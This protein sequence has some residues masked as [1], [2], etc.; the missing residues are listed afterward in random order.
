MAALFLAPEYGNRDVFGAPEKQKRKVSKDFSQGSG[1]LPRSTY[2]NIPWARPTD[3]EP[4]PE[5]SAAA[6]P[7]YYSSV[8]K[9][10]VTSI[11][12]QGA[13]GTCSFFAAAS[14][15]ESSALRNRLKVRNTRLTRKNLDLSEYQLAYFMY[16]R[17]TDPLKMTA[18]DTVRVNGDYLILGGN[19]GMNSMRL[20]SWSGPVKEKLAPYEITGKKLAS[21]LAYSQDL[22]HVQGVYLQNPSNVAAVKRLIRHLGA[23][24]VTFQSDYTYFDD[25]YCSYY[26][27]YSE[28]GNHSVSLVGWDDNFSR[29]HFSPYTPSEDGAW[30]IKNSWGDSMG[31]NGFYWI[32]YEDKSLVQDFA[33]AYDTESVENYD[34]N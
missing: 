19:N 21:S 30:L 25:D 18:G 28:K 10:Y 26:C 13:W 2:M 33:I 32:S 11:K 7:A 15:L 27:P 3:S 8:R 22:L 1:E 16:H 34:Y 24:S 5:P 4:G 12:D 17:Q 31:N 20:L 14:T 6:L 29:N 23:V 9:G